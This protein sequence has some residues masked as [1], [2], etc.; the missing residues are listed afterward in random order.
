MYA[1]SFM[2]KSFCLLFHV[3]SH[4]PFPWSI[5]VA[6]APDGNGGLYSGKTLVCMVHIQ[7]MHCQTY[8]INII[9]FMSKI[10]NTISILFH[11]SQL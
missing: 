8:S 10:S 9:F 6:K 5:Q 11:I 3:E 7:D 2:I 4:H 1:F